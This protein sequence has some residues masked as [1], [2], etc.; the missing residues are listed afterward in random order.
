MSAYGYLQT[1]EGVGDYV[2]FTSGSGHSRAKELAA[3]E[4]GE[5]NLAIIRVIGV[6]GPTRISRESH[7]TGH[8]KHVAR[9][10]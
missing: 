3:A 9:I 5:E 4:A 8:E 7:H 6:Y 1:C 10:V 2:R